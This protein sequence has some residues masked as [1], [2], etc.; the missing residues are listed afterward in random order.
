MLASRALQKPLFEM[1]LRSLADAPPQDL[2]G[3]RGCTLQKALGGAM[4]VL[5]PEP[6]A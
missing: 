2:R 5:Q 4:L 6:P 1:P 3:L